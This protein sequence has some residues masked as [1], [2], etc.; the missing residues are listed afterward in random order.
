MSSFVL[1]GVIMKVIKDTNNYGHYSVVLNVEQYYKGCG[2]STLTVT[3]YKATAA[4]GVGIPE[5]N[6]Y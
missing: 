2:P 5:V 3:G 6:A 4:C 1:R